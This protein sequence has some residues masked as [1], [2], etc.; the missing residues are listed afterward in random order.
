VPRK[1]SRSSRARPERLPSPRR[2]RGE[3]GDLRELKAF[4]PAPQRPREPAPAGPCS[5]MRA[6]CPSYAPPEA[7]VTLKTV[8][9]RRLPPLGCA[10]A[11]WP[12]SSEE[13]PN[14]ELT[15]GCRCRIAEL[16]VPMPFSFMPRAGGVKVDFKST[17]A[18]TGPSAWRF[19][20][21]CSLRLAAETTT[22]SGPQECP[23]LRATGLMPI[24]G[25]GQGMARLRQVQATHRKMPR[26]AFG[27]DSDGA[28]NP[29]FFTRQPCPPSRR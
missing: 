9:W 5:R 11:R 20:P 15:N 7:G 2:T 27:D 1:A 3:N 10:S 29:Q 25:Q 16:W 6:S 28:Q 12:Q 8:L 19:C 14:T 17:P 23:R 18:S 21:S 4:K 22:T 26:S 24:R 13:L